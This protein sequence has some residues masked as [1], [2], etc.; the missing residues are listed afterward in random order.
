MLLIATLWLT[1]MNTFMGN[2]P[3]FADWSNDSVMHF[4][5]AFVA[6]WYH[7]GKLLQV[8]VYTI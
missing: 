3:K 1:V 4:E 7:F 5:V 2:E 8:V 6:C